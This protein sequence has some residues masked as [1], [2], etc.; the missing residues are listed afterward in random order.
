MLGEREGEVRRLFHHIS[1]DFPL[2]ISLSKNQEYS[3]PKC[4]FSISPLYSPKLEAQQ[5]HNSPSLEELN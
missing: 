3:K 1:I 4:L 2:S 5:D